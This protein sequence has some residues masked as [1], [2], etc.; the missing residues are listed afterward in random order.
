VGIL[1]S[2]PVG[3]SLIR[4]SSDRDTKPAPTTIVSANPERKGPIR[5]I[6]SERSERGVLTMGATEDQGELVGVSWL[7]IY[8]SGHAKARARSAQLAALPPEKRRR[9]AAMRGLMGYHSWGQTKGLA[10]WRQISQHSLRSDACFRQL[11][12]RS[13]AFLPESSGI[14]AHFGHR[15]VTLV[16]LSS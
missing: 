9:L 8:A 7:A 10:A 4:R 12:S 5:Q 6:R 2:S 1:G 15:R 16:R 11:R 14:K 3:F 13:V